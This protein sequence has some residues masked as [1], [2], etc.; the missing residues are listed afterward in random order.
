MEQQEHIIL[1]IRPKYA[2]L[3]YNG[4]KKY[5][6]RKRLY[7]TQ[8]S[9]T[10]VPLTKGRIYLYES[11]PVQKITGFIVVDNF[12]WNM[13]PL[14][15][16]KHVRDKAGITKEEFDKYFAWSKEQCAWH[17]KWYHKFK[18]PV[19]P[20]EIFRN[21]WTVPQSYVYITDGLADQID[22]LGESICRCII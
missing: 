18:Q 2:D 21:T 10:G 6:L 16:W 13:G 9:N 1:S 20:E 17:I 11:L 3:I 14:R 4:S 12:L 22:E 5:E 19:T 8:V 7:P 15:L